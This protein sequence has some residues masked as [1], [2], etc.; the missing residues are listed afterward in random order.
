MYSAVKLFFP[1]LNFSIF[2]TECI[3]NQHLILDKGNDY[4]QISSK[5]FTQVCQKAPGS[6]WMIIKTLRR[7]F[8][9]QM[10]QKYNFLDDTG[11][12]PGENQTLHSTVRSVYQWSS[13]VV[14]DSVIVLGCFAASGPGPLALIEG[15]MN[16]ALYQIIL[17]ENVRPSV[18]ELKLKRSWVK[19]Q[20]NDPKP[21]CCWVKAVLHGRVGQTSL[22]RKHLCLMSPPDQTRNVLL[23]SAWIWQF[24]CPVKHSKCNEHFVCQGKCKEY[25]I[26]FRNVVK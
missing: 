15:T 13:M 24:S 14:D 17:Q 3:F 10:S 2:D 7:M 26:F 1:F 21:T 12:M 23:I 25:I 6:T 18:C 20:D 9:G 22:Q 4:N 11:L 16:S 5:K 19:Q 8:Y